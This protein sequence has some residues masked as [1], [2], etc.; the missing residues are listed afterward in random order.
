MAEELNQNTPRN[1]NADEVEK[2]LDEM[3]KDKRQVL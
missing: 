1:V 2:I 3:P